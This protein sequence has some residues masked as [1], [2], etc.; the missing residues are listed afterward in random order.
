VTLQFVFFLVF[1]VQIGVVK[2]IHKLAYHGQN[3]A[4]GNCAFCLL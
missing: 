3:R 1:F 2:M 4:V